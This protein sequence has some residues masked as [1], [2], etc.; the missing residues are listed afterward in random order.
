MSNGVQAER[1]KFFTRSA[2]APNWAVPRNEVDRERVSVSWMVRGSA[3]TEMF[4]VGSKMETIHPL[5]L[6]KRKEGGKKSTGRI[7]LDG[8]I[9]IN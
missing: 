3:P 1:I 8:N 4:G 5:L 7:R 2:W 6:Q 9:I